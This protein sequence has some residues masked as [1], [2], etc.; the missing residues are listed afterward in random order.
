M[1][2]DRVIGTMGHCIYAMEDS[3]CT[4]DYK[5]TKFRTLS[6]ESGMCK[7]HVLAENTYDVMCMSILTLNSNPTDCQLK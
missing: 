5:T 2:Q 3:T 6:V 7:P 1:S 4:C